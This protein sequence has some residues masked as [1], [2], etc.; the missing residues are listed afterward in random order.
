MSSLDTDS[1]VV[2]KIAHRSD[3]WITRSS[4]TYRTPCTDGELEITVPAGM[5]TDFAS[6]H[7]GK[8]LFPILTLL[9]IGAG[10]VNASSMVLMSVLYF[11]MWDNFSPASGRYSRASL[12]H[13][14]LWGGGCAV[15]RTST[16]TRVGYL[17]LMD[18][19]KVFL[20]IMRKDNTHRLQAY[21][22]FAG[23]CIVIPVWGIFSKLNTTGMVRL[24]L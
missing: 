23:V 9:L 3:K 15:I 19:N 4:M 17:S 13:D 2:E 22:I 6:T 5:E 14:Y 18:G 8:L 7:W 21:T 1:V 20:D 24:K 12:F 11:F 16:G 10:Q